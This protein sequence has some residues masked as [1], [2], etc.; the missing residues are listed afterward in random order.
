ME[1]E[2]PKCPSC[3][4]TTLFPLIRVS[5]TDLRTELK[6]SVVECQNCRIGLSTPLLE[7]EELSPFYEQSYYSKTKGGL[8]SKLMDMVEDKFYKDR[9]KQVLC[10]KQNGR[11]LDV[12]CGHGRFV[13]VAKEHGFDAEGLEFSFSGQVLSEDRQLKIHRGTLLE[14]PLE[15]NT[16]DVITCWHSFEHFPKPALHL[17]RIKKLLKPNGLLLLALP[18]YQSWEAGAPEKLH[19]WMHLDVPRHQYHYSPHGTT[20]MLKSV[21]MEKIKTTFQCFEHNF[22]GMLVTL[23][24]RWGAKKN[25]FY[26][27]AK[28]GHIFHRPQNFFQLLVSLTIVGF[29]FL[30]SPLLLLWNSYLQKI[31]KSGCYITLASLEKTK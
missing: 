30:V 31:G 18:N 26:D 1:T 17:Q 4:N 6:F 20:L 11:L 7:A 8:L 25:I 10:E 28:R 27:Y 16:Y 22:A 23:Q 2:K 14:I 3:G 9:L 24:N 12:G 21:G 19:H 29:S 15:D 5:D 13:L